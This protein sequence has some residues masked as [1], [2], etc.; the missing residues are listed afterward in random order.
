MYYPMGNFVPWRESAWALLR[1]RTMVLADRCSVVETD[2][3]AR[4]TVRQV[5]QRVETIVATL[6]LEG[7]AVSRT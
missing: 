3:R 2:G 1:E 4:E 6:T 5:Q 7:S